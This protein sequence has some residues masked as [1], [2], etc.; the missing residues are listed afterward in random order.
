MNNQETYYKNLDLFDHGDSLLTSLFSDEAHKFPGEKFVSDVW[1]QILRKAGLQD[2]HDADILLKC[3]KKVSFLEPRVCQ[4][5][6]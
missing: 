4:H 2:T 5:N 3:A 6:K 1:L